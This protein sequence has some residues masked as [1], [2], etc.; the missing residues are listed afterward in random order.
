M[1]SLY[2]KIAAFI[3]LL[4]G[5][6][7]FG[8]HNSSQGGKIALAKELAFQAKAYQTAVEK[9]QKA[10]L[11]ADEALRKAQAAIPRTGQRVSDEVRNNPT[12]ADC[13]VPD[14]VADRL[15]EGISAGAANTAR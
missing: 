6:Y 10:A 2:I 12:S 7:A 1:T 8:H 9:W 11:D 4:L 13:V 15:Q 14:A 3:A 5:A